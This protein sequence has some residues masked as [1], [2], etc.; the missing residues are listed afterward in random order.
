M[1]V[2]A[3][4]DTSATLYT[5]IGKGGRVNGKETMARRRYQEGSL[6]TRGKAGRKVWVGR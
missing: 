1:E 4:L 3:V 5:D 2:A 6:F